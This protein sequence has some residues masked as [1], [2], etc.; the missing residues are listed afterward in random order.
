MTDLHEDPIGLEDLAAELDDA[1]DP[2]E[3]DDGAD[4]GGARTY[5]VGIAEGGPQ[6]YPGRLLVS[7][8]P[9]GVLLIDKVS[10]TAWVFDFDHAGGLFRCRDD[11]GAPVDEPGRWRAADGPTYDVRAFDPEFGG[12]EP[13]DQTLPAGSVAGAA[14]DYRPVP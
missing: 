4:D 9:S 10:N 7:R 8:F 3:A 13:P 14:A 12:D 2:G 11:A 5:Y 6:P 1:D